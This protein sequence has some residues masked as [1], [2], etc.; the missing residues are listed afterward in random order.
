MG[1]RHLVYLDRHITTA[2]PRLV[3]VACHTDR[4][5][6]AVR[7]PRHTDRPSQIEERPIERLHGFCRKFP[8]LAIS[9]M[10]RL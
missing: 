7:L 4:A 5:G 6:R 9:S 1:E 3:S 8:L 10:I 2:S